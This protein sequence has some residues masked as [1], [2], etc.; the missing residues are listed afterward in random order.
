MYDG[1]P[2]KRPHVTM[3][4]D[5]VLDT[6]GEDLGAISLAV[7]VALERRANAAGICDPS[8]DTIAASLHLTR[9]SV[10]EHI[11]RLAAAGYV[12][13]RKRHAPNSGNLTNEFYL[14][15]HPNMGVERPG[16]SGAIIG[17]T[18]V[19]HV[20]PPSERPSEPA[21]PASEHPSEPSSPKVDT[22]IRSSVG[23]PNGDAP[24]PRA[25]EPKATRLPDDIELSDEWRQAAIDMGYPVRDVDW[26][27]EKFRDYWHAKASNATKKDWY[28]TWLVWIRE[29]MSRKRMPIKPLSKRTAS[30]AA[31]KPIPKPRTDEEILIEQALAERDRLLKGR[32]TATLDTIRHQYDRQLQDN[33]TELARLGYVVTGVA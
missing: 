31:S 24:T 9:R 5:A 7:Y 8:Y 12:Q 19:N 3:L 1:E 15:H 32:A 22:S 17:D 4:C 2:L 30:P 33:A 13:S 27:F 21:S 25:T 20:H 18:L 6:I 29:E 23:T 10:I 28:K 14:P 11:K 26:Q 16:N